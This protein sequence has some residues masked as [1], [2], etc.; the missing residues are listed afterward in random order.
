MKPKLR[1]AWLTN[2][3]YDTL[4][5]VDGDKVVSQWKITK[6]IAQEYLDHTDVRDWGFNYPTA[7]AISDYG[8]EVTGDDLQARIDFFIR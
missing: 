7:D 8:E 3:A 1:F 5:I 2:N 4:A 6:S